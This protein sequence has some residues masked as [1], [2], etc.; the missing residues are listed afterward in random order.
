[1][2]EHPTYRFDHFLV[3]PDSWKLCRDGDDIHLEPVVLK[4]LIYLIAHRDRLVTRDE[5]M[6]TVWGDTVISEAALSKAVARLRKALGDD[7]ADPRYLETVHSQGYRFVADVEELGG[8]DRATSAPEAAR[9]R[10]WRRGVYWG[11]AILA[12]LAVTVAVWKFAPQYTTSPDR[13]VRSLAVLPINN[14]TGDPGQDHYVEGLQEV[15][16]TE[17]SQIQG[18]RVTSR[19]S[20]KRYRDSQLPAANIAREPGRGRSRRGQP[21]AGGQQRR[22]HDPAD[23]WRQR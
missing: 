21:A 20:T 23:P 9:P 6:S 18:L 4:L 7:P 8:H 13:E 2:T 1:M 15:L 19:Q 22:G 5:L 11:A 3:D 14:L 16:I 12:A 10:V 17:L